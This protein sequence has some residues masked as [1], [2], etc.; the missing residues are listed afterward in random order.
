MLEAHKNEVYLLPK[1]P[2]EKWEISIAHD[3][4]RE[5]VSHAGLWGDEPWICTALGDS[6]TL[7]FKL[8]GLNFS[9]C[10]KQFS[11]P[12]DADQDG[13]LHNGHPQCRSATG[14][15]LCVPCRWGAD[16]QPVPRIPSHAT[17]GACHLRA[18]RSGTVQEFWRQLQSG[19][20]RFV[21]SWNLIAFRCNRMCEL[22]A[23]HV[24]RLRHSRLCHLPARSLR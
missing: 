15:S 11:D 19:Q 5:D 20:L 12:Y 8:D 16:L 23:R 13:N 21:L 6:C 17:C 4:W 14:L 24:Q 3:G 1:E 7:P 9:A 18:L 22:S 10:L 2:D